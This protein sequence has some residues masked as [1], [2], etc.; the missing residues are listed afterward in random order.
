M[1]NAANAFL[2][3]IPGLA[4]Q[5]VVLNVD[6]IERQRR[7]WSVLGRA[8]YR[9][10]EFLATQLPDVAV[11]DAEVIQEYYIR[12]YGTSTRLIK[13]G[14]P[15]ERL[16]TTGILEKLGLREGQYILYVSRLE[17]ENNALLVVK[18]YLRSRVDVPL[19][20]VGDAPYSDRYIQKVRSWASKGNVI[21]P[22][23]IYG[24]HYRELLSH[25]LCY[26]QATEVGG[27]HP[28]LIE[29]MGSGCIVL[30]NGTPENREVIGNAGLTYDFNDES[31]LAVCLSRIAASPG[32]FE[33]LRTRAQE[34]V[35]SHYNWDEVVKQYEGLF[36]EIVS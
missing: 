33:E 13:Y 8:F 17:P 12:E 9:F 29:A 24:E 3:W 5:K 31:D 19:V 26:V 20:L 16:R 25:A 21:V 32:D 23:A 30:G 22:G 27:T 2:C 7:K 18:A 10:G 11:S 28:A 14:A 15:V 1:C 34:R 6:G 36:Y 35:R 4:N